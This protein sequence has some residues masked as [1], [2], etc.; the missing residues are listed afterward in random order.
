MEAVKVVDEAGA[1]FASC[2]AH[3]VGVMVIYPLPLQRLQL[4]EPLAVVPVLMAGRCNWH[5]VFRLKCLRQSS[6]QQGCCAEEQ[7]KWQALLH[8]SRCLAAAQFCVANLHA[9]VSHCGFIYG[10]APSRH[11]LKLSKA[12]STGNVCWDV[13]SHD[14]SPYSNAYMINQ[15]LTP[16]GAPH[17]RAVAL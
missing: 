1:W 3:V 15:S 7:Q 11:D 2:H 10:P 14:R 16:T 12:T 4:A 5:D 8:A 13:E 17:A 6:L 9:N